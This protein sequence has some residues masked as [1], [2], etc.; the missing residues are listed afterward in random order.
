M[1][2]CFEVVENYSKLYFF[3]RKISKNVAM[4]FLFGHETLLVL[5]KQ[6][7]KK[8]R[9]Y[10]NWLHLSIHLSCYL[11]LNGCAE[12]H[13]TWLLWSSHDKKVWK[14]YEFWLHLLRHWGGGQKINYRHIL[15]PFFKMKF[16]MCL[17]PGSC[18]RRWGLGLRV[19]GVKI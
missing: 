17:S 9:G 8:T 1:H 12:I 5:K 18:S 3:S 16:N 6:T 4:S 15:K 13:Q 11:L 2:K 10:C 19:K 7:K 14:Q